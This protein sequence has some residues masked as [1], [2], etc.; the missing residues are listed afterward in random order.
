MA[1]LRPLLDKIISLAQLAFIPNRWIAKNQVT[2]QEILHS[3]KTRKTKLDL[4]AI[5]LDLQKAYDRVSWRFIQDVL[6]HLGFNQTFT[7]WIISC[8]SSV[9]FEFLSMEV[10]LRASNLTGT[11]DKGIH[12]HHIYSFW[13]K[14]SSPECW[15]LNF[16]KKIFVALKPA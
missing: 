14:K 6:L 11:L 3:F 15:T 9:S 10:K 4:M 2:V 7:S 8:I 16:G 1:K 5:K 12:S 13:G